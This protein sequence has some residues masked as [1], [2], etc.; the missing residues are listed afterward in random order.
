MRLLITG[1]NGFIG[2][3]LASA[4]V[5]HYDVHGLFLPGTDIDNLKDLKIKLYPVDIT[6]REA[7]IKAFKQ[8]RPDAVVHLAAA[9]GDFNDEDLFRDVNILGLQNCLDGAVA[10][11]TRKFLFLSSVMVHGL[12]PFENADEDT[13]AIADYPD[14]AISKVQGEELVRKYHELTTLNTI[15]IRPG[16]IPFG[17]HDRLFTQ[18]MLSLLKS[19]MM[20]LI[21]GGNN[22]INPVFVGNLVDG[23]LSAI[24]SEK[25]HGETFNIADAPITFKDFLTRLARAINVRP[26]PI[27]IPSLPLWT[28][29]SAL[30]HLPFIKKLPITRYRIAISSRHFYFST[31]KASTILNY[32]P[33][34][35]LDEAI[36]I[37]VNWFTSKKLI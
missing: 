7:T 32:S 34:W 37:T 6:D 8:V 29:A 17:P 13:P 30:E 25:A 1:I 14:Y 27:Y 9:L 10:A 18:G 23:I 3:N 16:L 28:A 4:A 15:I 19:G 2:T 12:G 11:G 33:L 22:L 26:S 20:P 21:D 24:K 36:D 35:S 31:K 5:E